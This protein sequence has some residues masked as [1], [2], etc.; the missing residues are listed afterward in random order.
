MISSRGRKLRGAPPLFYP[1][2]RISARLTL[3]RRRRHYCLTCNGINTGRKK[4][5]RAAPL[6]APKGWTWKAKGEGR[7]KLRSRNLLSIIK[8]IRF[9]SQ[10][11]SALVGKKKSFLSYSLYRLAEQQGYRFFYS[12]SKCPIGERE[13]MIM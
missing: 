1:S 10:Q 7:R 4:D 12:F 2:T 9:S 3:G 6:E 5:R 11:A 13:E 8:P